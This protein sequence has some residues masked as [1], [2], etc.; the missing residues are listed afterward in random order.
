MGP[1]IADLF[2]EFRD[3]RTR[4]M[5]VAMRVE[6]R[7]ATAGLFEASTFIEPMPTAEEI[8]PAIGRSRARAMA[9]ETET[10]SV[11]PTVEPMKM[12]EMMAPT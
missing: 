3:A 4:K 5:A 9:A 2:D 7:R 11:A 6:L 8:S 10:P 1:E 12:V